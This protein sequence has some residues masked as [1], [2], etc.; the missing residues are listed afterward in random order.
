MQMCCCSWPTGHRGEEEMTDL[1]EA[2]SVLRPGSGDVLCFRGNV[3]VHVLAEVLRGLK[4]RGVECIA[5]RLGDG[6]S[7]EYLDADAMT[8]GWPDGLEAGGASACDHP[9]LPERPGATRVR[10]LPLFG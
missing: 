2:V 5:V 10:Q 1:D 4:E 6:V 3:D 7:V 8:T 9:G